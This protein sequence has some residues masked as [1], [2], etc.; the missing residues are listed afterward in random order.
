MLV[1]TLLL[2]SAL[3]NAAIVCDI[4]YWVNYEEGPNPAK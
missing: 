4:S 3:N 1:V 2:L